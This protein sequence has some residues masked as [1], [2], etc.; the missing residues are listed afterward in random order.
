M[1]KRAVCSVIVTVCL[2]IAISAD[3]FA[4]KHHNIAK[5][6]ITLIQRTLKELGYNPGEVDG[7]FGWKTKIAVKR[8]QRAH[9]IRATGKLNRKTMKLLFSEERKEKALKKHKQIKKRLEKYK[10]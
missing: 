9:K 8:F 3:V 6:T 2:L 5:E 4:K 1:G 7:K 10:K